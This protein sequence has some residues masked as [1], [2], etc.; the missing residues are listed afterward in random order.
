MGKTKVDHA[1]AFRVACDDM[2]E[3]IRAFQ[4]AYVEASTGFDR[5]RKSISDSA[6]SS[7]D[8]NTDDS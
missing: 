3:A 5:M 4:Q 2:V 8:T 1:A 7:T 6:D